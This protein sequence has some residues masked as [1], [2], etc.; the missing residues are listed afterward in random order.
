MVDEKIIEGL[1]CLIDEKEQRDAAKAIIDKMNKFERREALEKVL[2]KTVNG[3]SFYLEYL[4]KNENNLDLREKEL[5]GRIKKSNETEAKKRRVEALKT[6]KIN[7][8]ANRAQIIEITK[9][10]ETNSAAKEQ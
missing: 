7:T 4:G 6:I 3:Y 9:R 10:S 2:V 1:I 5:L 8:N